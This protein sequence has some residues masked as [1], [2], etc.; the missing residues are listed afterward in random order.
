MND[1][2]VEEFK[3]KNSEIL[4]NKLEIDIDNNDDS[5]KLTIKNKISLAILKIVQKTNKLLRDN[6]KVNYDFKEL[7]N[8]F[9]ITKIDI[10]K[11][12]NLFLDKRKEMI[13]K[14]IKSNLIIDEKNI[15]DL[16]K[17]V[18]EEFK[19]Q[20]DVYMNTIIYVDIPEKVLEVCI[21]S[22]QESKDQFLDKLKS[23]D[24]EISNM[25]ENSVLERNDSL[26]NVI[27]ENYDKICK[28]NEKAEEKYS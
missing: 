20:F 28:L 7:S 3:K 12:V 9:D 24:F 4:L 8:I 17:K 1:S 23:F 19:K 5:L 14:Q 25:I 15:N 16:L 22:S 10:E 2:I 26:K 21:F 27:L 13:K 18:Y 11:N 6:E